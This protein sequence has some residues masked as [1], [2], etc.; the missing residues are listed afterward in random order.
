M[1]E[2]ATGGSLLGDDKVET[3][4]SPVRGAGKAFQECWC[5][6]EGEAGLVDGASDRPLCQGTV[7]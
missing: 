3:S 1:L 6:S 5:C 2:R 7:N 4:V